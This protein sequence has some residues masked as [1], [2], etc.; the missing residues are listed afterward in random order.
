MFVGEGLARGPADVLVTL[1]HEAAHG[2]DRRPQNPGHQP[3]GP[4]AQ[5]PATASSPSSTSTPS[6]S[7][8][9]LAE[10]EWSAL[11]GPADRRGLTPLV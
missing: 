10:E 7:R 9:V 6:C 2:T 3:P 8:G 4:L 5:T 11:L 1:L